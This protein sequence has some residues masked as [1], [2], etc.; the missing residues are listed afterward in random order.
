MDKIQLLSLTL[1]GVE[2]DGL[3][4]FHSLCKV[5]QTS[6]GQK[7]DV[8]WYKEVS[9]Q[10]QGPRAQL[11]KFVPFKVRTNDDEVNRAHQQLL[12]AIFLEGAIISCLGDLKT[13][14]RNAYLASNKEAYPETLNQAATLLSH[15]EQPE[16]N[17]TNGC[18]QRSA[19]WAHG[20]RRSNQ[21]RARCI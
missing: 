9:C 17:N 19:R 6:Q 12:T 3:V 7:N 20:Q 10:C 8:D 5:I 21:I 16:R 14:L 4:A 15:Y 18:S 2:P 13:H 1:D 11:G